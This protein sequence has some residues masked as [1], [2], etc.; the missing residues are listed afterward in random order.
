[1]EKDA[2]LWK[3]LPYNKVECTACNRRCKIPEGGRGF[4][5][6]RKN[7]NGKLVLENYGK[8]A[9]LQLDPIEKKPFNHYMPGSYVLGIGTVSC[10]FSCLFCQNHDLSKQHE[11]EG[12]DFMP[13]EI[14]DLA[15][16]NGADGIA[17]TYN[18]PTIFIE[19]ALDTA[20][21]AHEKGL[22]N[23]FV[24]NGYMTLEAVEKMKGKI[25]AVVVDFKGNAEEKF[26]NK[27]EA[28]PSQ[29]PIMESLVAMRKAGIHI[30][31]T[32]L[33][34]PK[35]GD[36][37]EAA[38]SLM[39]WIS[40]NLGNETPV[41]FTRFYPD[42]KMADFPITPF[43]E[44][45]AHYDIAK[46]AGLDYVYIGN[47]PGNP[48]ENTYC[49]KCGNVVIGREG[50]N[51]TKWKISQEGNC[52]YCGNHIPIDGTIPKSIKSKKIRWLI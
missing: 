21:V 48:F 52:K 20:E 22:F 14:V 24:S 35:V 28:I 19:Y 3:P 33:V 16:K 47:V 18:E 51:I 27:Y 10:N 45:K 8:L 7:K 2:I 31:I 5:Y 38:K 25:D 40:T 36:S 39:E 34:V 12:R 50:F 23:V 49:P 32:D 42:Y 46:S 9:A 11:T 4:C 13:E 41:Q 44:L 43:E 15:I 26:S 29:K 6:I 17:Y 30:E 1:M 37:L